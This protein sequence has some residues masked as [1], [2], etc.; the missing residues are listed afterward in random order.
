MFPA[1]QPAQGMR[2]LTN[3]KGVLIILYIFDGAISPH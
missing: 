3:E 1:L 2:L